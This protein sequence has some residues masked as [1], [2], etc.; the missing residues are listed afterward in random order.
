M[1]RVIIKRHPVLRIEFIMFLNQHVG[2]SV[3]Q[4]R[5]MSLEQ[6]RK[7][8]SR[9]EQETAGCVTADGRC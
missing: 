5:R 6:L 2:T 1:R 3:G 4:L 9:H 7:A 8:Y